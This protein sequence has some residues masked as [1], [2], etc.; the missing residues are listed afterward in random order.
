MKSS[1][2]PMPENWVPSI[3][4]ATTWPWTSMARAPLIVIILLVAGDGLGRVDEL[5]RQEGDVLV[6]VKPAVELVGARGEG[7]DRDAVVAPLV[8]VRDLARLV[9]GHEA[10]GEHLGVDAEVAP[11]AIGELAWRSPRGSCR[12][13]VWRVAPSGTKAAACLAISRSVSESAR[14]PGGA[15]ASRR[16][17]PGCRSRRPSGR[18]CARAGRRTCA[19]SWARSRPRGGGPGPRQ[20]GSSR[21]R[22]LRRGARGSTSPQSPAAPRPSP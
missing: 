3:V 14:R 11:V 12:C 18:A 10:V 19:D 16:L 4:S 8:G 7:G 6:L 5:D 9:E 2:P 20:R 13:P 17:R 21:W 1:W 15:G 22:C